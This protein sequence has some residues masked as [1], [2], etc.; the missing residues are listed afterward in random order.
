MAEIIV[1]AGVVA[2]LLYILMIWSIRRNCRRDAAYWR[3]YWQKYGR[4]G[5]APPRVPPRKRG[6]K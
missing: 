5:Q 6:E 1:A 3:D 2:V 4:D